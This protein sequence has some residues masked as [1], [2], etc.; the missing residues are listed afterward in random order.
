MNDLGIS[1]E[2]SIM[3]IIIGFALIIG[4]SMLWYK[5]DTNVMFLF[6]GLTGIMGAG[7]IGLGLVPYIIL[8]GVGP[9]MA[10]VIGVLLALCFVSLAGVIIIKIDK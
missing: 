6:W 7:L 10:G 3:F 5:H 2:I 9:Q 8:L 4:I 1:T